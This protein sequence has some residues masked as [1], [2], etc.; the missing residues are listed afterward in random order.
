MK[1]TEVLFRSSAVSLFVASLVLLPAC[2]ET[3]TEASDAQP[4]PEL[5]AVLG[6]PIGSSSTGVPVVDLGRGK[7]RDIVE[8]SLAVGKGGSPTSARLWSKAGYSS[9]G[10]PFE[11]RSE[12][13]GANRRGQ[14]VG[15]SG[16]AGVMYHAYLWHQ[17]EPVQLATLD[18]SYTYAEDINDAGVIV[19]HSNTNRWP[20]AVRWIKGQIADLGTLGRYQSVA[21]AINNR[22]TVVGYSDSPI[23]GLMH[24]VIWTGDGIN[25]LGAYQSTQTVGQDINDKG[26]VVGF[27]WEACST[28]LSWEGAW[29][30]LPDLG[31]CYARAYGVNNRGDIVGY[32]RHPTTGAYR[33]VL[34]S[35]EQVID[36]GTLGGL[37]SRAYAVTE[38]G[39]VV[40]FADTESDGAH[41]VVWLP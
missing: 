33:G 12:A 1:T 2:S 10:I 37:E 29:S 25:D 28:A 3:P 9:L 34:W 20:H 41:A 16:T 7:A 31:D 32:S 21:F 35:D 27:T 23:D 18:G 5:H 24:A 39:M 8:T 36:L 38:S 22:G 13:R 11:T 19:G 15:Y 17:G 30:E 26:Q 14:V 4:S 6:L 40:G